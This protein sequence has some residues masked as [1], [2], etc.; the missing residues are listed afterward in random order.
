MPLNPSHEEVGGPLT[1]T[2]PE[3]LGD[4]GR[5]DAG[6]QMK[7]GKNAQVLA[8]THTERKLC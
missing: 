7:V 2:T 4:Q 3:N 5:G 1:R 8:H 6:S